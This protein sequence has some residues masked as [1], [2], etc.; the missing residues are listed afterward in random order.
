MAEGTRCRA[1]DCRSAGVFC[2]NHRRAG[3]AGGEFQRG[4]RRSGQG[5]RGHHQS[6]RQSGRVFPE[7][8]ALGQRRGDEGRGVHSF[9][10]Y[11]RR[12]Q[13]PVPCADAETCARRGDAAGAGWRDRASHHTGARS[14]RLADA[15]AHPWPARI[16]HHA[17]QGIGQRGAS[18]APCAREHCRREPDG[19]DQ[20]RGRQLQCAPGGLSRSAV[21]A[22][23]RR[24]VEQLGLAFNPTP[25]RSSRTM[26]WPSC[27]TP[28][29][30]A[31]PF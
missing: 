4:R 5:Y 29:R 8:K 11:L 1:H 2:G 28:M 18:T 24:F 12:H 31:T 6:R 19:Q 20:R 30:A 9:R 22:F 3:C 13:Q 10:L 23:A 21:E 17:R 7:G 14:G 27:S 25:S 16:A 26:R 15:G